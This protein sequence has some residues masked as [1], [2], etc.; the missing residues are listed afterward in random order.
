MYEAPAA[1]VAEDRASCRGRR[2]ALL[3]EGR[4]FRFAKCR[5]RSSAPRPAERPRAPCWQAFV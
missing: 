1:L 3:Q 5:A 2:V 4:E